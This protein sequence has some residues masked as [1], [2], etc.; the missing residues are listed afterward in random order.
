MHLRREGKWRGTEHVFT[1]NLRWLHFF[2][3]FLRRNFYAHPSYKQKTCNTGKDQILQKADFFIFPIGS[4]GPVSAA[5]FK[6][7][8]ATFAMRGKTG[9]GEDGGWTRLQA[10]CWV[11]RHLVQLGW[12]RSRSPCSSSRLHS[13]VLILGLDFVAITLYLVHFL[14]I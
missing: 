1:F 2:W 12:P 13:P 10:L 7:D 14:L 6:L 11:R 4:L 9:F 3:S 5:L 8:L